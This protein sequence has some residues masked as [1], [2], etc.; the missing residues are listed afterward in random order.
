MVA[1]VAPAV[2]ASC[3]VENIAVVD[4]KNYFEN[5]SYLA[6]ENLKD[7]LCYLETEAAEKTVAFRM[8]Y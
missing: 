2:F 5:Q 4:D 6:C 7:G 3:S 8:D 1:A